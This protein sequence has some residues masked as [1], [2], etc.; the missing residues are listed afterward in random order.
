MPS[1]QRGRQ[2]ARPLTVGKKRKVAGGDG[3]TG[4]GHE[5]GHVPGR[6]LPVT[7]KGQITEHCV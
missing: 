2:T 1:P 3:V 5:G 6:A 7:C 4:D